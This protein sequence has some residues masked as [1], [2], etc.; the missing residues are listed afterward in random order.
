MTKESKWTAL[1]AE[2]RESGQSAEEFCRQ[3]ELSVHSLRYWSHRL[4]AV[5]RDLAAVQS[6]RLAQVIRSDAGRGSTEVTLERSGVRVTVN[7]GFDRSTLRAVLEL[8]SEMGD[9]GSR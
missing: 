3:R 5:K 2:W 4:N 8:L 9:A 1:V 7:S 6:V